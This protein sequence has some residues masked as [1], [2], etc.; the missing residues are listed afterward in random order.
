MKKTLKIVRAVYFDP[1]Q[2]SDYGTDVTSELTAEILHGELHFKGIYNSIFP[3]KFKR[4]YKRLMVVVGFK[5]KQ[6]T[7]YYNE[8]EKIN[9]P[10]D[11]GLENK[12]WWDGNSTQLIY[13]GGAVASI[14]GL[15]LY[16][17]FK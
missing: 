14:I 6:H 13:L 12:K 10:S 1:D 3:D 4:I 16:L 8:N 7:K 2:G 5:N 15:I 9:L 17:L 11:L